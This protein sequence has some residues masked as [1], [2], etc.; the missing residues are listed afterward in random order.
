MTGQDDKPTFT[1]TAADQDLIRRARE[2]FAQA[3][4]QPPVS[5]RFQD[6]VESEMGVTPDEASGSKGK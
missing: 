3:Q 2:K 1:P 6:R 5:K 4:Q